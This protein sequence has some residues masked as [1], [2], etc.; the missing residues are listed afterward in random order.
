MTR[1]T[2]AGWQ[3]DLPR[4]LTPR[5]QHACAAYTRGG[6][7]VLLV[8]GGRDQDYQA[9][10]STE[11]LAREAGAGWQYSASLPRPLYGLRAATVD[12]TVIITGGARNSYHNRAFLSELHTRWIR[13]EL[14]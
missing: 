5:Y 13:V 1:Y 12:R 11:L 10:S 8:A 14:V 2:T 9:L 6:V 3:E 4:L 7:T